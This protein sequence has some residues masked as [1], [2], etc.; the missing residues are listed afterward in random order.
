MAGP[1][2]AA[3]LAGLS[4]TM[5]SLVEATRAAKSGLDSVRSSLS[6]TIQSVTSSATTQ[7]T[8][9]LTTIPMALKAMADPIAQLVEIANPAIITQFNW[10]FKD[11][12]GV[13]GRALLP[14]MQSFLGAM[15]NVGDEIAKLEPIIRSM[16]GRMAQLID[17]VLREF[18]RTAEAS[19][20]TME[21][22]A[23]ALV[24]VAEAGA[25]ATHAMIRAQEGLRAI[26]NPLLELMGFTGSGRLNDASAAGAAVRN[27]SIGRNAEQLSNRAIESALMQG[28]GKKSEMEVAISPLI[29]I[30][31]DIREALSS[32][33]PESIQY[34]AQL[35]QLAMRA[36]E[37]LSPG[38]ALA[39]E[40]GIFGRLS[41]QFASAMTR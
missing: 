24:R 14:I 39:K 10:A 28:L 27:V 20:P 37:N 25:I 11:T 23:T 18:V 33:L 4:S 38:L 9:L 19:G 8:G 32:F 3:G 2:I 7:L 1:A 34:L 29:Q 35:V 31:D 6:R 16:S 15:R 12:L 17:G 41:R 30:A 22:L 26:I 21:F 13:I 36:P 5:N 40:T